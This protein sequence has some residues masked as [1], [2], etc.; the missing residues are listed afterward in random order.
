MADR[1]QLPLSRWSLAGFAR[2]PAAGFVASISGSTIWRWLHDNAI[3]MSSTRTQSS[4]RS[5][6][7]N[8]ERVGSCDCGASG[9]AA[10]DDQ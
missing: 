2:R 6:V 7:C 4:A 10:P 3:T 8:Q 5:G 9:G 1:A